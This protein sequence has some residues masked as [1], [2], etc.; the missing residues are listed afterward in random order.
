VATTKIL[1][2]S[3]PT[4]DAVDAVQS[5]LAV[6]DVSAYRTMR[7]SVGN[8]ESSPASLVISI[9]HVNDPNT[10]YPS[11]ITTLDQFTVAPDGWISTAYEVP[12]Q[13]VSISASPEPQ[14][15]GCSVFF[16]VYARAD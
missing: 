4:G 16:T 12:G 5:E 1:A 14:V 9:A 15:T 11:A 7:L 3:S 10:A 6:L 13:T 2:Q 8:W